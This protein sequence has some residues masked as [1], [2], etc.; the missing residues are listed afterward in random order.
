MNILIISKY[1]APE[2]RIASVRATK[3]AKYLYKLTEN[4]ITVITGIVKEDMII[5]SI[6]EKD[7]ENINN[8]IR[9]KESDWV[10]WLNNKIKK[11]TSTK[12]YQTDYRIVK[13]KKEKLTL[14]EKA[15]KST[16]TWLRFFINWITDLNFYRN[17]KKYIK[18]NVQEEF[19]VIFST[20]GPYSSHYI[21][22]YVKSKNKNSIW[23]ADYRDVVYS[24]DVPVFFRNYSKNYANRICKKA[25]AITCISEGQISGLYLEKNKLTY[26]V[27]NGYDKD[28]LTII[29][30][31]YK[32]NNKLIFV[33]TGQL[34]KGKRDFTVFFK[35][36]KELINDNKISKNNIV[37]K[38]AG[39]SFDELFSQA[40]NHD[41]QDCLQNMG[42]VKREQSLAMQFNSDILLL[43][44]WNEANSKGIITG[45]FYEYLM[46]GKPII[47]I[48]SG[49]EANSELKNIMFKTNT[50]YC[51]EQAVENID[52]YNKLKE[53]I[54][55]QYENKIKTGI[56]EFHANI[57]EIT[58]YDYIEIT[59]KIINIYTQIINKETK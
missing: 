3:L 2:N 49:S 11:I 14:S 24:T 27:S 36:L 12:K 51:F 26:H 47:S 31:K 38:Y 13:I 42:Y 58:K 21:G 50:G 32:K 45:K 1:F 55:M 40:A 34:Y 19:D 9:I 22:R 5:D 37:I 46:I 18:N 7:I 44:S 41:M 39:N 52:E 8:I 28:D 57:N 30:S 16:L 10:I 23:I 4:N 15:K 29:N 17:A 25:D 59:K 6:L 20:Y 43:A 56:L 54:T 53:Y 33:Y 48:I 35:A